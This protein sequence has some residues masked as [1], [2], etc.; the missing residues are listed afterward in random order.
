MMTHNEGMI[1][2]VWRHIK[3]GH[4]YM[5]TGLCLLEREWKPAYLYRQ[6]GAPYVPQIARDCEEWH[7]GRF[8]RVMAHKVAAALEAAE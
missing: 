6:L 5:I 3:S 8:V 1:G 7:D 4:V 2:T